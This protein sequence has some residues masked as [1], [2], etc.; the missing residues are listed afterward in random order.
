MAEVFMHFERGHFGRVP[1]SRKRSNAA[2]P[3]ACNVITPTGCG[4]DSKPALPRESTERPR[5]PKGQGGT[6]QWLIG[7]SLMQCVMRTDLCNVGMLSV[8]A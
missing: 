7:S 2:K 1:S 4:C 3:R 8:S 6:N 5:F